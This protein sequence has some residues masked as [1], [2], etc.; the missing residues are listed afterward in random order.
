MVA[1]GTESTAFCEDSSIVSML[2]TAMA[3]M[4]NSDAP[5]LRYGFHVG[6]LPFLVPENTST[7]V[8][9]SPPIFPVPRAPHW[10]SGMLNLRGNVIPVFDLS[11]LS[12]LNPESD[13]NRRVLVLGQGTQAVAVYVDDLPQPLT[14]GDITSKLG[15]PPEILQPFVGAGFT[16]RDENWCE[17]DYQEFF[18]HLASA[19]EEPDD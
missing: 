4:D 2:P 15:D 10:L 12:G 3:F 1:G 18:R 5:V 14:P 17:F 16:D 8:L 7:E 11:E 13:A 9:D 6:G 19:R